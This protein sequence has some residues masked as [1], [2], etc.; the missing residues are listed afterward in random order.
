MTVRELIEEL[1]S[2]SEDRKDLTLSVWNY[3]DGDRYQIDIVDDAI[4]EVVELNISQNYLN[5]Q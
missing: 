2:I 5:K 3:E 4:E 1:E